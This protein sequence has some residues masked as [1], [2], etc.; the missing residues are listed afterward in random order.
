[1]LQ[2]SKH[3]YNKERHAYVL[4]YGEYEGENIVEMIEYD[5]EDGM[6]IPNSE[7]LA[8]ISD[9]MFKKDRARIGDIPAAI[10][11]AGRASDIMKASTEDASKALALMSKGIKILSDNEEDK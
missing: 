4:V 1:M 9:I 5:Y 3:I 2:A 10:R 6:N 11:R 7:L 8:L